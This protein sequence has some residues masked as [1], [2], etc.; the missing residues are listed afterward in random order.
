MF[1]KGFKGYLVCDGYAGY[2][3]V[4]CDDVKIQRCLVHVRR[5]FYDIIKTTSNKLHQTSTAYEMVKK[6]DKLF[7]EEA[8]F[9]SL[10]LGTEAIHERRHRDEYQHMV[11]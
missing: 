6:I 8:N 5:N 2:N 3:D 9:S 1:L 10:K 11:R 4:A 7:H